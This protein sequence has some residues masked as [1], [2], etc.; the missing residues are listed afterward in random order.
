[1][2]VVPRGAAEG[3]ERVVAARMAGGAGREQERGGGAPAAVAR[4]PE[5]VRD[6][7]ARRSA[8]GEQRAHASGFAEGPALPQVRHGAALDEARGGVPLAERDG[9]AER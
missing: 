4:A 8:A 3:R 2:G 1:A 9:V 5:R 7:V 6:V